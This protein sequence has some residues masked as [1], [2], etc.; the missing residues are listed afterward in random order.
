M[1]YIAF[2]GLGL[3]FN[4]SPVAFTILGIDIHWYGLIITTGIILAILYCSYL[5]KKQNIDY[6]I[7]LDIALYGIPVSVIFARM[8]Y[9]IFSFESYRDNLVDIFKI[10][11]GGI[12]IYGAVIGAVLT[13]YIYCKCKKINVLKIFDICILG[14]MIGQIIGRWGNFV[15]AEAYGSVTDSPWR[16]AIYHYGELITVHPTFLY[17]SSWNL[18]GFIILSLTFKRKKFNGEIFFSYLLWYGIGRFFI[19]GLRTDSLYF[20]NFRVSQIVAI[21][22]ALIGMI[23][24]AYNY[25]KNLK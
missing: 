20:F 19:E 16:M 17:E 7:I 1:N 10:W 15:N 18:V 23:L 21:V 3:E 9:V 6:N 4:I 8:Y 14:V 24:L 5:A 2:P 22:T 11:N 25:K 12:A 13:A